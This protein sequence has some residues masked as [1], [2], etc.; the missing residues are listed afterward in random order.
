[1]AEITTQGARATKPVS[2]RTG[3]W[4]P[5]RMVV[6]GAVTVAVAAAVFVIGSTVG[7]P[8]GHGPTAFAV[9]RL[10][11]NLTSIT[12]VNS[13]ASAQQMTDQLHAQGEPTRQR[14]SLTNVATQHRK[15]SSASLP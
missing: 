8:E 6:A 10:P 12:I 9:E 2:R 15:Q 11:N 5:A 7:G 4:R 3:V 1:M 13:D 14:Q